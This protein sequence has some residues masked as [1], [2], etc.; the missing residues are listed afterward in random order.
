MLKG[1]LK[2]SCYMHIIS[3]GAGDNFTGTYQLFMMH[4]LFAGLYNLRATDIPYNP[5]F[6][7]YTLLE[8]NKIR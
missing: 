2:S 8:N 5:F 6:M 1:S 4:F 7:S 3:S